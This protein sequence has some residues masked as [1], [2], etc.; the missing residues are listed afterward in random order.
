MR[1]TFFLVALPLLLLA[2]GGNAKPAPTATP[3]ETP[4]P[5]SPTPV[6]PTLTPLPTATPIPPTATPVPPTAVPTTPPATATTAPR[7][8]ARISI[9]PNQISPGATVNATGIG[10]L[11]NATISIAG[12]IMGQSAALGSLQAGPDGSFIVSLPVPSIPGLPKGTL[13]ATIT[14]SD[15]GGNTASAPITLVIN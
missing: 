12:T 11:P 2:C 6:P 3:T 13:S 15:P 10:F 4:V 1:R 8:V 5:A 7:P 14:A 9:T